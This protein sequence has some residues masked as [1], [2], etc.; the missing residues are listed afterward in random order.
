[1][2]PGPWQIKVAGGY[3]ASE[4]DDPAILYQDILIGLAP[5]KG[6]NNGEPSLHAKSIGAAD[7][8]P[9]D[10]VIHIG[11]GTGYYTAI[12]AHL[13]GQGGRVHAY[14]VEASLAGRAAHNLARY[15]TVAVYPKSALDDTL[16]SADVIYVSAGATHVPAQWLDALAVGGRLVLPLT[17]NDRL[18]FMLLVTR[19]SDSEC[20][21]RVF[22]PA[23]FIPCIG[24][25]D[26]DQ[27]R[28]LAEALDARDTS[29]IRSLKRGGQPDQTAWCIGK[30]WWLSTAAPAG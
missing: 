19:S 29:E 22:S 7:P 30:G 24:V 13:V 3:L 14:E 23:G 25:R 2:G 5:D 12:L 26:D 28:A 18:G 8:Q 16:A 1:V 27:S 10:I 6:I 21:A 9:S 11:A 15:P 4:T 20:S 17:P